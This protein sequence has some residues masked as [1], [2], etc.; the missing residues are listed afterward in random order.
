MATQ[1]IMRPVYNRPE[2]LYLSIE[3]EIEARNY[4][5][6]PD[7]LL[8]LFVVEYGATQTCLD[9]IKNYPSQYVIVQR[10]S[11][12]R[13]CAN[14]LEGIKS[15]AL[16]EKEIDYVINL[17]DDCILHKTYFKYIHNAVELL[18]NTNY[19][20]ITSWGL[21]PHGD[22]AKLRKSNFFC[23][24]GTLINLNF[25][26]KY[27]MPYVNAE[28]Y[29]NFVP[30]I[31]AINKRNAD[32]PDAK[33]GE[34]NRTHLDWDGVTNRLI[35]TAIFEEE[36]YSYS[37]MCYRLLHIGFYGYNRR[38]GKGWPKHLLTFEDRINYLKDCIFDPEA[39]SG[40][41]GTYKD[42]AV[43]DSRLDEWGGS[44]ELEV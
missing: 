2:M 33:Y 6:F 22:P 44:L 28:Y 36:I 40:L 16:S 15:V 23:D 24:P 35:D 17:E 4:Y 3:A 38:H 43:F 30:T 25:F 11:R 5:K 9:I 18:K 8:T 12:F 14:I 7:D 34:G 1:V 26:K 20:V 42:Y 19:S 13:P 32:N 27:V 39:L 21:S 10:P 37:S 29:M 41:D 31:D